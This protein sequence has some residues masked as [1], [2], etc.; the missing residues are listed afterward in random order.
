MGGD[1]GRGGLDARR[2]GA[3]FDAS[4]GRRAGVQQRSTQQRPNIE[5][6]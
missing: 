4:A 1:I 6:A 5:R 3:R 2:G